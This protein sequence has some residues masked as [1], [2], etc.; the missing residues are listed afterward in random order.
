MKWKRTGFGI[1]VARN[2]A[3]RGVSSAAGTPNQWRAAGPMPHSPGP[4]SATFR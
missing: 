4:H 1:T 2:A 3:W